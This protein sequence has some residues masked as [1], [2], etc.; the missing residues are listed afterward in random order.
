M[1]LLAPGFN[2]HVL[3]H[4]L[5]HPRLDAAW[6]RVG[7]EVAQTSAVVA[8]GIE[9][10]ALGVTPAW[11]E[12]LIGAP[13]AL[14]AAS[15]AAGAGLGGQPVG[16]PAEWV[17]ASAVG[18]AARKVRVAWAAMAVRWVVPDEPRAGPA[19][20]ALGGAGVAWPVG[21]VLVAL[22]ALAGGPVLRDELPDGWVGSAVDR[23]LPAADPVALAVVVPAGNPAARVWAERPDVGFHDPLGLDE[24]QQRSP[25]VRDWS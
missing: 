9:A 17:A 8:A 11:A 20:A 5:H 22:A 15:A 19:G 24:E 4:V 16:V 13:G 18:S 2:G 3:R 23:V 6:E 21:S 1:Q 12:E 25:V 10:S 7:I 14:Q